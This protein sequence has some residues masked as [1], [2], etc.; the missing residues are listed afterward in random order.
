MG[1]TVQVEKSSL[2]RQTFDKLD[3]NK[4]FF[5]LVWRNKHTNERPWIGL[6]KILDLW[7]TIADL[8]AFVASSYQNT[9][10]WQQTYKKIQTHKSKRRKILGNL[11][12]NFNTDPQKQWENKCLLFK[13]LSLEVVC[14]ATIDSQ[15]S[16]KIWEKKWTW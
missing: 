2:H 11:F 5:I 14:Y 13:P 6:K 12:P 10:K 1:I 16:W 7:L 8:A 9:P 4:A 3:N 15:G